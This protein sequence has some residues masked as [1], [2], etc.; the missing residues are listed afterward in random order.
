MW[1]LTRWSLST[2]IPAAGLWAKP[3]PNTSWAS[4]THVQSETLMPTCFSSWDRF[5]QA[6]FTSFNFPW[7]TKELRRTTE[8]AKENIP[9]LSH[10]ELSCHSQATATDTYFYW[11]GVFIKWKS[12]FWLKMLVFRYDLHSVM[13]WLQGCFSF[14]VVVFKSELCA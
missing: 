13:N 7:K 3:C 2:P 12:L 10:Q 4:N 8:T 1:E 11:T 5:F 9:H 14:P 6:W